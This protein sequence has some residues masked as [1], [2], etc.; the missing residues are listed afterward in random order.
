[1]AVATPTLLTSEPNTALLWERKG[2]C[3]HCGYCCLFLGSTVVKLDPVQMGGDQALLK[4][5]GATIE[6]TPDGRIQASFKVPLY[7]PCSA[8][9]KKAQAAKEPGCTIQ[10]EKPRGCVE[11]PAVPTDVLNTPCSYWFERQTEGGIERVGG[12]ASGW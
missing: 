5:R 6:E 4:L 1:M 8:F 2:A 11:F 10:E 7:A 3:V 9:D 12:Q